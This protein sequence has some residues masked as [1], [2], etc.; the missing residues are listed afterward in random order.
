MNAWPKF[1]ARKALKVTSMSI[2]LSL[3]LGS[4]ELAPVSQAAGASSSTSK[5]SAISAKALLDPPKLIPS[6][7]RNSVG[8]EIVIEFK[9]DPEWRKAITG[10]IF[11]NLGVHSNGYKV[12]PGKI[13][14]D[15]F[16]AEGDVEISIVA[17]GYSNAIVDQYIKWPYETNYALNKPTIA[18]PNAKQPS[19]NAVDGDSE[20]RWESEFADNQFLQVDLGAVYELAHFIIRWENAAAKNY[21]V[22]ISL[23]GLKWDSVTGNG[24]SDHDAGI[25]RMYINPQKAR[26]VKMV[27]YDRTTEYGISMKEFEVYGLREYLQGIFSAPTLHADAKTNIVGQPIDF[28]FED[29]AEWRSAISEVKVDDVVISPSQ[30]SLTAGHMTFNSSLFTEAKPYWVSVEAKGYTHTMVYQPVLANNSPGVPTPTTAPTATPAPTTAPTATPVQRQHQRLRLCQRQRQRLRL[31]Q[32]QHQ[33][34]RQRLR[35]CQRQHPR[36]LAPILP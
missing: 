29:D 2:A 11:N 3:L 13:T 4:L 23:D 34:Q 31:L 27:G 6:T 30:Y 19:K 33:R 26:Y 12:E 17:T 15:P 16:A 1:T 14:F 7:K 9:D 32:R 36:F 20:T 5:N 10:V 35:L 25:K 18:S 21:V 28:T 22:Q 24:Y 8:R